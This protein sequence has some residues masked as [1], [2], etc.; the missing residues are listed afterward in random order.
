MVDNTSSVT[1]SNMAIAP[2]NPTSI[3]VI[4]ARAASDNTVALATDFFISLGNGNIGS[5][6]SLTPAGTAVHD[7][8]FTYTSLAE[9]CTAARI[10]TVYVRLS[11]GAGLIFGGN[12][13]F[14]V[15]PTIAFSPI[16]IA[17]PRALLADHDRHGLIFVGSE[18][19]AGCL[20]SYRKNTAELHKSYSCGTSWYGV[21][22]GCSGD[23]IWAQDSFSLF[24]FSISTAAQLSGPFSLAGLTPRGMAVDCTTTPPVIYVGSNSFSVLKVLNSVDGTTLAQV[25]VAVPASVARSTSDA[26]IFV[27]TNTGAISYVTIFNKSLAA[28]QMGPSRLPLSG[29]F[30]FSPLNI[31]VRQLQEA[32][33]R[34]LLYVA[35]DIVQVYDTLTGWLTAQL[36]PPAGGLV[37]SLSFDPSLHSIYLTDHYNNQLSALSVLDCQIFNNSWT[38]WTN[39]SVTCGGNGN[40]TRV[41]RMTQPLNGGFSC[42]SPPLVQYESCFAAAACTAPPAQLYVANAWGIIAD[43]QP[44]GS[45]YVAAAYA[46]SGL[47]RISK[48]TGAVVQQLDTAGR[49]FGVAAGCSPDELWATRDDSNNLVA[50]LIRYSLASGIQLGS[51]STSDAVDFGFVYTLDPSTSTGPRPRCIAVDCAA[52]IVF[53]TA[54]GPDVVN[55]IDMNSGS[56]RFSISNADPESLVLDGD[57][58][59]VGSW[60]GYINVFYKNGTLFPSIPRLPIG[61][62]TIGQPFSLSIAP[63]DHILFVATPDGVLCFDIKSGLQLPTL[64]S[65]TAKGGAYYDLSLHVLWTITTTSDVISSTQSML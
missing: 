9:D 25:S 61:T 34:C 22:F 28:P 56:S 44:G 3:C 17:A 20:A 5:L 29:N 65:L 26:R 16:A 41:Q 64:T 32:Q 59:Y 39:C 2:Y 12:V 54:W 50:Q 37:G 62:A 52:N 31:A 8:T 30:I 21:D 51:Q 18:T 46:S 11:T 47:K 19:G 4:S 15:L 10:A 48:Q 45:L 33:S 40:R 27:L 36:P 13:T 23:D 35:G 63:A 6:S 24:H 42:P 58:L 7:L 49:Y 14:N 1:C 43:S 53:V 55:A 57:L 38:E 60:Q